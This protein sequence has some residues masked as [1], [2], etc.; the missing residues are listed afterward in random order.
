MRNH[1]GALCGYVGVSA[2]HPLY[3]VEYSTCPKGGDCPEK[4]HGNYCSHTPEA[5]LDVHGGITYYNKCSGVICHIPAPGESDDVFWFGFD[6]CHAGDV[7]P[8]IESY[9]KPGGILHDITVRYPG[10]HDG[11]VYRDLSYVEAECASLAKQ[12]AAVA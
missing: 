6:C 1:V 4:K 7:C 8:K 12:L 5:V 3:A 9:R 11:E 2:G 10:V